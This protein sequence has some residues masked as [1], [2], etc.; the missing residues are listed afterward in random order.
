[1][2]IGPQAG[3]AA[4]AGPS[5]LIAAV[6][7]VV[8]AIFLVL[9]FA[10]GGVWGLLNDIAS[11]V[12]M[13]ATIPVVLFL[14]NFTAGFFASF[15]AP[16]VAGLGVVGMLGAAGAQ[17][18]LVARVRTYQQLLPWTLGF[19]AVV[20]VWYLLIAVT[21]YLAGMPLLMAILAALSG[22]SFIALG[23]G[24]LRGNERH[25]LSVGGGI[26]LLI[27]STIFLVWMGFVGASGARAS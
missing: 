27:A 6:A 8:G 15:V 18:L 5:A 19:G 13:L 26:V 1:M 17:A 2:I 22:V 20:G 3:L 14:A 11:I 4:L 23:Y 12:L 10:K 25:P 9:F 21:G 16:A 24:F 7:T